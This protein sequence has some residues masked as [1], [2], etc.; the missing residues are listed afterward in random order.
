MKKVRKRE[1]V[2]RQIDFLFA[3]VQ[4]QK[5]ADRLVGIFSYEY[6]ASNN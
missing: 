5:A 4:H 3:N 2:N 6:H 1:F